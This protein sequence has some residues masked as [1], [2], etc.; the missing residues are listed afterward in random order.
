M[1]M[2]MSMKRKQ[3]AGTRGDAEACILSRSWYL[4]CG[5]VN[6][7]EPTQGSKNRESGEVQ[8]AGGC[9]RYRGTGTGTGTGR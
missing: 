6:D 4:L 5:A 9:G 8:V 7:A 2:P 3:V 1:K